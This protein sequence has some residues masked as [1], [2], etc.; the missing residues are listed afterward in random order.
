[1]KEN[2]VRNETLWKKLCYFTGDKKATKQTLKWCKNTERIMEE[3]LGQN[4]LAYEEEKE[5]ER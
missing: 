3:K 2:R 5:E 4:M 1:M